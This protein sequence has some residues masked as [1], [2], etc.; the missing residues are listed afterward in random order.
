M[1]LF[2]TVVLQRWNQGNGQARERRSLI[3]R[4]VAGAAITSLRG[5]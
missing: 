3:P 4:V 1:R 5:K 2:F